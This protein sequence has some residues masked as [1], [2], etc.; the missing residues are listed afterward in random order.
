MTEQ[1]SFQYELPNGQVLYV[2]AEVDPGERPE[3]A[4]GID[5]GIDGRVEITQCL[6]NDLNN[7]NNYESIQVQ[8]G[9]KGKPVSLIDILEER[10]W[11]A[12]DQ[13]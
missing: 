3:K 6:I 1:V 12:Y 10:A 9:D 13:R 11:D 2:V 7:L 8:M 4:P 5:P